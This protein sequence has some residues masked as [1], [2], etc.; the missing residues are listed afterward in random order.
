MVP[1]NHDLN[2]NSTGCKTRE[3]IDA[4]LSFAPNNEN[5]LDEVILKSG[6]LRKDLFA[7]FTDYN[8]FAN[9]FFC[10]EE[11]MNKCITGNI[12][13]TI[14]DNDELF[15]QSRLTKKVGDIDVSIRGVNTAL[16]CDRWD[17]NEGYKEGHI[18]ML[19]R[20]AYRMENER[21]QE[22]RII[23]GHHPIPFLT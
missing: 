6:N 17:W 20:R 21:K 2:R 23:M 14:G 4:S 9:N 11:L 12:E 10:Q 3:M 22:L 15:Y 8:T 16:N 19:P 18:Q 5:F 7:A 1:G 13:E